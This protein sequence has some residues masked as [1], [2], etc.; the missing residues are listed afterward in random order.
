MR[1]W[2]LRL[3]DSPLLIAICVSQLLLFALLPSCRIIIALLMI[4]T[5]FALAVS[6]LTGRPPLFRVQFSALSVAFLCMLPFL[7]AESKPAHGL[8]AAWQPLC[9]SVLRYTRDGRQFGPI[10]NLSA[11]GG[12]SG[13]L[14]EAHPYSPDR[15]LL[16]IRPRMGLVDYTNKGVCAR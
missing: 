13:K 10:G 1:D 5:F 8:F 6:G 9:F 11:S 16:G 7:L 2:L 15:D 12:L 14:L 3:L 4:G